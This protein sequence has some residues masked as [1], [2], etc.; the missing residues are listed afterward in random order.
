MGIVIGGDRAWRVFRKGDIAIAL[1]W[2]NGDP[3]MV[4]FPALMTESRT[5]RVVPFVIPLA[6][7]H[8]YVHSDGHPNLMRAMPG[9]IQAATCLGMTPERSVVHRIIDAI[10]E[11]APD[12]VRMPPEPDQWTRERDLDGAVVGEL[13]IQDGGGRTLVETEV[14][15]PN[16]GT[17]E[18]DQGW[19]DQNWQ[20]TASDTGD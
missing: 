1:H 4:L 11:T 5:G 6:V 2:I 17:S 10:V 19:M 16:T 13:S 20:Q 15:M 12:L 14:R 3:A 8:E 9:A 7:L 18:P